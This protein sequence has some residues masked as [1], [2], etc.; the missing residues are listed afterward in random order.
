[1]FIQLEEK[2]R[3]SECFCEYFHSLSDVVTIYLFREASGRTFQLKITDT[4]TKTQ[5]V[6]RLN[7]VLDGGV[8]FCLL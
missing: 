3:R 7:I 8:L 1:M 4:D 6:S 2:K 5:F